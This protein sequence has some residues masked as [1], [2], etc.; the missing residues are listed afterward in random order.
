MAVLTNGNFVVGSE[1]WQNGSA[2]VGAATWVN[3]AT[4]LTGPVTV[5]NSLVGTTDGDGVGVPF[6]LTNGNYIVESPMWTNGAAQNAGA[7]TWGDGSV[8]A[9][10][11]VSSANSLVG[12]QTSDFVSLALTP[13]TPAG[14]LYVINSTAWNNGTLTEAGAITLGASDG[15]TVASDH[16]CKQR[17]R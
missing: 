12:T 1:D 8:G 9:T 13:I 14:G 4:G 11:V 7:V 16:V 6:A 10:G 3:G 17:H 5:A 2:R 15:G